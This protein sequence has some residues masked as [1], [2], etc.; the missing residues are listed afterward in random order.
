[1][2]H[3]QLYDLNRVD[4][5]KDLTGIGAAT[6]DQSIAMLVNNAAFGGTASLVD[7]DTQSS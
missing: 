5:E 1:M 2:R 6:F 7:S 4:A 3:G